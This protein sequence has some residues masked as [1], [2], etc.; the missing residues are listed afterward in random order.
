MKNLIPLEEIYARIPKIECKGL[1]AAS[2]GPI[3]FGV[4]EATRTRKALSGE[5]K[6]VEDDLSCKALR[7]GQCM[8]YDD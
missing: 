6:P 4:E 2:C 5:I 8:I 3:M 1:C 7:F